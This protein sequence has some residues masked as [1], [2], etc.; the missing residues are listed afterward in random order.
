MKWVNTCLANIKGA[1]TGTCRPTRRRR[2][3]RYLADYEYRFNRRFDLPNM[4]PA[5]AKAAVATAPK[6][7]ATLRTAETFG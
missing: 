6:P 7:Y 3:D 4:V 2:A 5:L 1:I